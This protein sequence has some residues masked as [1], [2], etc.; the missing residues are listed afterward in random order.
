MVEQTVPCFSERIFAA[1]LAFNVEVEE[2]L[3][4]YSLALRG[5]NPAHR[6]RLGRDKHQECSGVEKSTLSQTRFFGL[7]QMGYDYDQVFPFGLCIKG[8][9]EN[10]S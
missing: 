10:R 4:G 9:Q 5:D 3:A 7:T 8:L 1:K 6:T 2:S